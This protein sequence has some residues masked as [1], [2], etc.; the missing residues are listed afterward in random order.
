MG[1]AL[2]EDWKSFFRFANGFQLRW[3]DKK[4]KKYNAKYLGEPHT[5][6]FGIE[7]VDMDEGAATGCVN[8]LSLEDIFLNKPDYLFGYDADAD[9]GEG[10]FSG[11]VR[12]WR[13]FHEGLFPFDMFHCLSN[14]A[15][16]VEAKE[17]ILVHGGFRNSHIGSLFCDLEAYLD[18]ILRFNGNISRRKP[19]RSYDEEPVPIIRGQFPQ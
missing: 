6:P 7:R 11:N 10:L 13:E 5:G 14:I 2:D 1:I 18:L 3:A 19:F 8:I 4:D 9:S 12:P 15:A 16:F 17:L